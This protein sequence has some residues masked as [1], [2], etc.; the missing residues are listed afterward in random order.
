MHRHAG[1]LSETPDPKVPS[2]ERPARHDVADQGQQQVLVEQQETVVRDRASAHRLHHG[3]G[4]DAAL[5]E[6]P[7]G[8]RLRDGA[9]GRAV[10][11]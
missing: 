6:R 8:N 2:P 11:A 10:R 5:H 7:A 4:L 1:K 9:D 3:Q